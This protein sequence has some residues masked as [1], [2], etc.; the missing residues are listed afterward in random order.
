MNNKPE[1]SR[2]KMVNED[3]KKSLGFAWT[4]F[5]IT[6]ILSVIG[7]VILWLN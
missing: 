7:G 6:M 3:L 5:T 2:L 4:M 1:I